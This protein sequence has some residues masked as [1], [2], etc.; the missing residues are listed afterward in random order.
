MVERI[1]NVAK[2]ME[3]YGFSMPHQSFVVN[4][5]HVKNVKNQQIIMDNQMELPLSQKKQKT[6]KQ[7]LMTYLS[8]R[9]E[10]R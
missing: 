1:T 8:G 4:M 3:A 10:G 7:E 9:L 2:R 6:W 5:F